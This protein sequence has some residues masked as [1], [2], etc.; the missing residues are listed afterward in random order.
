VEFRTASHTSSQSRL[1][2]PAAGNA[3]KRVIR[4]ANALPKAMPEA[5]P[6]A[7]KQAS[8]QASPDDKY[9]PPL[10]SVNDTHYNSETA[11]VPQP[12]HKSIDFSVNIIYLCP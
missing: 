1:R 4:V 9:S 10:A 7:G 8:G 11:T 6:K 3:G 12:R 5:A 2:L